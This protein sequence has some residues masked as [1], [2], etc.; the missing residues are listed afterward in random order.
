MELGL[1]ILGIKRRAGS[2]LSTSTRFTL[3]AAQ[4]I[5][6]SST[7]V[8]VVTNV[9]GQLNILIKIWFLIVCV[10]VFDLKLTTWIIQIILCFAIW[11][12]IIRSLHVEYHGVFIFSHQINDVVS[13]WQRTIWNLKLLLLLFDLLCRQVTVDLVVHLFQGNSRVLSYFDHLFF[14]DA[15]THTQLPVGA[16]PQAICIQT[17]VHGCVGPVQRYL[18]LAARKGISKGAF[19]HWEDLALLLALLL[20]SL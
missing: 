20:R 1:P 16:L 3:L 11:V 13:K 5:G 7:G 17:V 4:I 2:A 10:E 6:K 14:V 18:W 8:L 19:I 12:V 9:E 15:I